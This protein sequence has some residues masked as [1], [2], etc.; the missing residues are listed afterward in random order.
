MASQS[1]GEGIISAGIRCYDRIANLFYASE[2]YGSF[3]LH[4]LSNMDLSIPLVHL[5]IAD[6]CNL[7]RLFS[8]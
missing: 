1:L 7:K 6:F 5:P 2:M 3:L 4:V 8:T